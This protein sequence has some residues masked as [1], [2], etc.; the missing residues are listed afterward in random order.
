VRVLLVIL[1]FCS[2]FLS[3]DVAVV[4]YSA[5]EPLLAGRDPGHKDFLEGGVWWAF[6]YREMALRGESL[7][8]SN[9]A[10]SD[11]PRLQD[12]LNSVILFDNIPSWSRGDW[13]EV[14]KKIPAKKILICEE[15]PV[16]VPQMYEK[17]IFDLFDIVLTWNPDLVDNKKIFQFYYPVVKA[18]VRGLPTFKQRHILTQISGNKS[19]KVPNEL[20]SLRRKAINYFEK[21]PKKDFRFFG[22]GWSNTFR[23]Y[24]GVVD[25]KLSVLQNYRF[26]LCF[27][28][29]S[30]IR[31]YVTEKIF[32]C[33][34]AGCVP[35]YFGATDIN[36]YISSE[37]YVRWENF[38]NFKDLYAYLEAMPKKEYLRYVKNARTFL[39]S[40]RAKLFSMQHFVNTIMLAIDR[41][42]MPKQM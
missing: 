39:A 1:F 4:L 38:N 5:Y 28:N 18:P 6:I 7:F 35:V 13:K 24:G 29:T 33:L 14:V 42:R 16:V 11:L 12:P 21:H 26:S 22:G 32:D 36:Q 37:C 40:D 20:Y 34:Q 9:L 8:I 17:E 10:D 30:R 27:E 23:T 2:S 25:S 41:K 15:P 19:S 3:A 31:G